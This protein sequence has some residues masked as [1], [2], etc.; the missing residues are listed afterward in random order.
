M[1]GA[2]AALVVMLVI[3]YIFYHAA[4]ECHE[5]NGGILCKLW[6]WLA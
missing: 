3:I 6:S 5:G 1:L 2:L 4:S